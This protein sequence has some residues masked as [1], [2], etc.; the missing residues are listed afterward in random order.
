MNEKSIILLGAGG[1]AKVLLDMILEQDMNII[2]IFDNSTAQLGGGVF[3]IPVIGTDDDIKNYS[4]EKIEL[5]NGIGSVGVMNLRCKIFNKFKSLG[6]SFRHV[7]HKNSIISSRVK[8]SEGVQIMAGAVINAGSAIGEN[9]IINT[10]TSI[11]HDCKIGSHVHI[12]PGCTLSGNVKIGEKSHIGTGSSIIQGISIGKNVLIGAGSV[13]V[14]DIPDNVKV[15][16]VPARIIK[17]LNEG[18]F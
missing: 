6:Y 4:P 15:Y 12:A 16:G 3:K 14:N 18:N 8:I 11:D 9:S 13:V 5:I 7:I 17:K 10:K 1:H 2:G